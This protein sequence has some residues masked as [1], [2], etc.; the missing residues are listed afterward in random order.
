MLKRNVAL[1]PFIIVVGQDSL[2]LQSFYIRIDQVM[3]EVPSFIEALFY[4]FQIYVR[5]NV[6]Y[7]VQS[8][9]VYY[10]IQWAI[11]NIETSSDVKIPLVC[12]MIKQV[13]NKLKPKK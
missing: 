13:K 2:K 7:P 5:F 8:E 9:N 4:L 1:Q 11:L 12:G 3:Y 6:S 10:F